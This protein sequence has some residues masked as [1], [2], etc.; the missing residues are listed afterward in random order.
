MINIYW[1]NFEGYFPCS[2]WGE[3]EP[4]F[5]DLRRGLLEDYRMKKR[6]FK[7]PSFRDSLKNFYV[8]R[9]PIDVDV[10]WKGDGTMQDDLHRLV[11]PDLRPYMQ[12][13]PEDAHIFLADRPC[14]ITVYPAFM[15]ND[16]SYGGLMGSFDCGRWF[17]QVQATYWINEGEPINI[18][19]GDALFYVH[20]DTTEKVKLHRFKMTD[21]IKREAHRNGVIKKFRTFNVLNDLYD[22]YASTRRV[23]WLLKTIKASTC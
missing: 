1:S 16:I 13:F 6:I 7:C 8:I 10:V 22:W 4:L 5:H 2:L 19:A 12:F 21:D 14:N 23:K 9:S 18:K 20:F 11:M 3:P 15:H 17:R